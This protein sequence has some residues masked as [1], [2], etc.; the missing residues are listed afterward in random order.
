MRA[1][2]DRNGRDDCAGI[3]I[4]DAHRIIFEIADV[5]LRAGGKSGGC[6][7]CCQYGAGA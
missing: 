6:H 3:G 2:G 5:G 7:Q 4:D 1:G